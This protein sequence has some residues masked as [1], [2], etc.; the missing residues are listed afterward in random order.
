V[1]NLPCLLLFFLPES[2]RPIGPAAIFSD[3]VIIS[4]EATGA[5]TSLSR[6]SI[7]SFSKSAF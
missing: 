7:S 2:P 1:I 3:P 5:C 4:S 6:I